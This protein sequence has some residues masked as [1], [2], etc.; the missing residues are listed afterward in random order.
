MLSFPRRVSS[1]LR[2]FP[3]P[4]ITGKLQLPKQVQWEPEFRSSEPMAA[5]RQV[6]TP[7]PGK[8]AL[9]PSGWHAQHVSLLS[10]LV[11]C[12]SD[13]SPC[14]PSKY[15]QVDQNSLLLSPACPS[16]AEAAGGLSPGGAGSWERFL[17]LLS[18]GSVP[19]SGHLEKLKGAQRCAL[20]TETETSRKGCNQHPSS[21]CSIADRTVAGT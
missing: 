11:S 19:F 3:S 20:R 9:Q 16:P 1:S 14:S 18:P 21:L 6:I 5:Y 13:L 7:L 12:S 2:S 10:H 17:L 4:L 8:L 15:F